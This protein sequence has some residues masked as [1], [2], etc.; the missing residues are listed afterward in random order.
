MTWRGHRG[1]TVCFINDSCCPVRAGAPGQQPHSP[2]H[3]PLTEAGSVEAMEPALL[4]LVGVVVGTLLGAWVGSR[5]QVAAEVRAKRRELYLK[6]LLWL[7]LH[8][9]AMASA[10]N[11]GQEALP[12]YF[13]RFS[14]E[15]GELTTEVDMYASLKVSLAWYAIH[16]RLDSP[17]FS[18]ELLDAV[19]NP[20]EW[21]GGRRELAL[22]KRHRDLLAVERQRWLH[23][24]R[25]DIGTWTR[26]D[27]RFVRSQKKA[28]TND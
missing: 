16:D 26:E 11:A 2:S 4:A 1:A 12:E 9:E 8:P 13:A 7:D 23:A 21:T 18:A 10:A 3:L 15:L 22:L 28:V 25:R 6:W 5:N 20:P 27:K 17:D 14:H 19:M 24:M